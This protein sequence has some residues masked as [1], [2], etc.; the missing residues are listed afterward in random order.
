MKIQAKGIS[1]AVAIQGDYVVSS[2]AES[3]VVFKVFKD[4]VNSL[5]HATLNNF[6]PTLMNQYLALRRLYRDAYKEMMYI[7]SCL[8]IIEKKLV[9]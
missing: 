2:E 4:A 8:E 9:G 3:A 1:D 7:E 6:N 5:T